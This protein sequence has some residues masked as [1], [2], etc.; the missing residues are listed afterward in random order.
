LLPASLQRFEKAR[1]REYA[2]TVAADVGPERLDRCFVKVNEGYRISKALREMC[3]F[4]GHDL[5]QYPHFS[6]LELITWAN[7][8]SILLSAVPESGRR[9]L[10][11][12]GIPALGRIDYR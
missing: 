3:V 11:D 9:I 7:R 4:S 10:L 2:Q 12:F 8:Q 1:R 5:I 6:S